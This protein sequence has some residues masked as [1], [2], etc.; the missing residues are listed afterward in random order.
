MPDL[1]A[2]DDVAVERFLADEAQLRAW[3]LDALEALPGLAHPDVMTT[4]DGL[5]LVELS[6]EGGPASSFLIRFSRGGI[7]FLDPAEGG[8]DLTVG[9]SVLRF[10][11][12]LTGQDRAALLYLADQLTLKG[13]ELMGLALDAVL[14][15][16]HAG[17]AT[18]DPTSFDPVDV[19]RAIKD[20][21]TDHLHDVMGGSLR[22]VIVGEVF[23]RLPDYLIARKAGR[24]ELA[25]GFRIEGAPGRPADRYLVSV[26]RGTC[27][28]VQDPGDDVA[29]DVTLLLDGPAFL[30]LV[31]GHTNP[32]RA[33]LS[34]RLH[35]KGDPGKAL[36][37]NA[38]MRIPKP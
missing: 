26:R 15:S 25:V 27:T 16:A 10:A 28:V 13:D 35:L 2:L 17:G 4:L 22:G 21:S 20:V 5:L 1:A 11:R 33:V 14:A 37:F 34:G 3:V 30:R 6:R 38:M 8:P 7:E 19:S 36:A 24:A 31:L 9:T 18:V 32:V 12:I 23:R 29:R